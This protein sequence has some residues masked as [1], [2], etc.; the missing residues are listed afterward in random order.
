M[1]KRD[2][3]DSDVKRLDEG[4][5]WRDESGRG[6]SDRAMEETKRLAPQSR[7]VAVQAG[8]ERSTSHKQLGARVVVAVGVH[9]IGER[10]NVREI[11]P[12]RLIVVLRAKQRVGEQE[13][14]FMG[15]ERR[16]DM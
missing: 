14:E 9:R 4:E 10:M 3:K 15:E 6:C 11:T 12:P 7:V 16:K 8:T 13:R 5:G 2:T 1:S